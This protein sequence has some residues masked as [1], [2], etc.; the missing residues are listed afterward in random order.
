MNIVK[1]MVILCVLICVSVADIRKREVPVI[2]QVLLLCLI[3][4]FFNIENVRGVLVAIPFFI[5]A[6]LTDKIGG[7]DFKIIALLGILIG[8]KNAFW[9]VVIGCVIFIVSSLIT[10]LCKGEKKTMY[11]FIPSLTAGYILTILWEA[12]I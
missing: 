11:P 4:F 3:P 2:S 5:T 9:T 7:G 8:L 1:A 10:G 12:I 6:I